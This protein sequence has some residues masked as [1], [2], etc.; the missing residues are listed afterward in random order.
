MLTAS[1]V[2]YR[3][4][5]DWLRRLIDCVARSEVDTL[6]LI[7]NDAKSGLHELERLSEKIV[8]VQSGNVGYGSGHNIALRKAAEKGARYH[9]VLNPDVAFDP[10]I[11]T[12][13]RKYMDG[14]PEA[15]Q[16]MPRVTFPDGGL[17][18]L[19]K[20]LPTPMDLFAKR[21]LPEAWTRKRMDRFML[22]FTGYDRVMNV[23]FLS[24]SFMFLRM[25]ALEE[26]GLFDERFFMY[27]E[28][29][30]LTRRMHRE[31]QTLYYPDA[32][33]THLYGAASYK[34]LKMLMVH[35]VS[36]VKYFNKWGWLKDAERTKVNDAVLESLQDLRSQD[37]DF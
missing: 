9:L 12:G 32:T 35:I 4:D 15:G 33:I 13:M 29:I 27:A 37:S 16:M 2:I 22:R 1:I 34:S 21:F 31:Y 17:Q 6:Y 36:V 11:I 24:G 23:P 30:D 14:H 7:N 10:G 25:S 8:Y 3:S 19:C 28:D 5:M 18:Y 26:V 20:L